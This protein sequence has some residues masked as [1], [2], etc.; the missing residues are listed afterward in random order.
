MSAGSVR[1]SSSIKGKKSREREVEKGT[2]MSSFLV[3]RAAP[4]VSIS[5]KK[6]PSHSIPHF[7]LPFFILFSCSLVEY[8]NH[9]LTTGSMLAA[10]YVQ[11]CTVL[12]Y[13]SILHIHSGDDCTGTCRCMESV[14]VRAL[15]KQPS[16]QRGAK[17][18]T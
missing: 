10:C 13:Y 3:S 15:S 8:R 11:H 18:C 17:V 16:H 4:I 5:K 9:Q 14:V 12:R 6:I 7:L 1:G 2:R